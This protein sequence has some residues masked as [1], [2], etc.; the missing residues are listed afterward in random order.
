MQ[1]SAVAPASSWFT[2][3]TL[4]PAPGPP[5]MRNNFPGAFLV[6]ALR[7]ASALDRPADVP[8]D[9]IVSDPSAARTTPPDTGASTN[10]MSRS[11]IGKGHSHLSTPS[12]KL[13]CLSA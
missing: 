1:E 7:T 11:C 13:P 5:V 10:S 4:L 6:I 9:I 2:I 3:L 12:S 8:D